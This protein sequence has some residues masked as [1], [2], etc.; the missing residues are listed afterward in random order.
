MLVNFEEC[1]KFV[2]KWEG[3]YSNHELDAGGETNM[4]IIQTTYDAWR[5][6]K[7]LPHASVKD[8]TKAEV[9]EIY[10]ARYWSESRAKWLKSPL[11]LV[12]F[13]TAVN[14]GVGRSTEFLSTALGLTPT[15][16]WTQEMSDKIHGANQLA[17][18]LAICHQRSIFR[19]RR[20][21][22]NPSQQVFLAGWTNRDEDLMK[23]VIAM[24]KS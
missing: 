11:D 6:S 9:A 15:M 8:I 1:L 4:G 17:L 24:S 7:G 20:V 18:A 13:D 5:K 10:D 12:V 23:K 14:M 21:L 16:K 19:I 22:K 3:G 2:L